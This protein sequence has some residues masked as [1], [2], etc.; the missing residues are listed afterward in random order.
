M[1]KLVKIIILI[2]L[3]LVTIYFIFPEVILNI[4]MKSARNKADLSKKSVTIEDHTIIYLEGGKGDTVLLLHG[5]GGNKDNWPA[6]ARQLTPKYHIVAPD[7]PGSGESTMIVTEIYSISAQIERLHKFVKALNI[8]KFHIVGNAMGGTIAGRYTVTH[9]D[10]ILS[11]AFFNTEGI[12]SPKPSEFSKLVSKGKNPLAAN[13]VEE[14]DALLKFL[15]VKPPSI[16][17]SIK[18]YLL[19]KSI[20]A[21]PYNTKIFWDVYGEDYSMQKDLKNIKV[22]TLVLWGD[23][24]KKL[25]VSS[26]RVLKKGLPKSKI[27]IIKNCGHFPMREKPAEAAKYY[28]EFLAKK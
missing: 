21:R 20:S 13:T 10:R 25:H 27:I 3:I 2:L 15:F 4:S 22:K 18:K 24:D 12:K 23:M 6:F 11:L 16:P 7:L 8:K 26:T 5:L 14:F 28:S 17:G 1:K 9:P 19:K